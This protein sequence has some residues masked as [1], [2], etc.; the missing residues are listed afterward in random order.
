M[1]SVMPPQ[2]QVLSLRRDLESGCWACGNAVGDSRPRAQ[3]MRGPTLRR[4]A[5]LCFELFLRVLAESGLGQSCLHD[6]CP[7]LARGSLLQIY[8]LFA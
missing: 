6:E 2:V 4:G 5:L 7:C 3:G 8:G 1:R